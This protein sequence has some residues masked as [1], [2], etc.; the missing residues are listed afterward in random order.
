MAQLT[1]AL[2]FC[3][4]LKTPDRLTEVI[5]G[6]V[7]SLALPAPKHTLSFAAEVTGFHKSAF[8]RLLQGHSELARQT[9]L[10]L[11]QEI[12]RELA[13]RH[14]PLVP[15]APWTAA[16]IIDATLHGRSSLHVQ[17]SQRFNHGEGFVIGHQWTNLVL[18]IAGEVVPL[19]PIP[20][21]SKSECRRRGLMYKTEHEHVTH[22]LKSLDLTAWLGR[23]DAHEIVVLM[24][25]GY[26]NKAIE[27]AVL[28]RGWDFVVS[29]KSHRGAKTV[30]Q[31]QRVRRGPFQKIK[32]LFRRV[33]RQ[34][35]W[36]TV[37]ITTPAARKKKRRQLRV[38]RI[39][40]YLKG[41]CCPVVLLCSKKSRGKGYMYMACSNLML[42]TRSIVIAYTCRW[43]IEL[44][45]RAA[46]NN[47]GML[48]AGLVQFDSMKSHVHWVYCAYL[49]LGRM[50]STEGITARQK[51]LQQQQKTGQLKIILQLS[52]RF[53]GATQ[54]RSHCHEAIRDIQA[55]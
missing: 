23:Y 41:I 39:E 42:S 34:A 17:N 9:L 4:L 8:S 2:N 27:N 22:F 19:P 32:E 30:H 36:E 48:D 3:R 49:L 44:F 47:L 28:D 26:D 35:P 6:Y 21:L 52:T 53:Q 11:S 7:T 24:D 54:V 38:R 33:K 50:A 12:A 13:S 29:L 51:C 16:L 15:D 55:A 40:G 37:R 18:V 45:H 10:A 20:F 31:D 25:A 5:T 1:T 43:K 14:E 46:K